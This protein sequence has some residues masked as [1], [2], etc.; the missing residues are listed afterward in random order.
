MGVGEQVLHQDGMFRITESVIPWVG[1]ASTKKLDGRF[2][3][4]QHD[5]VAVRAILTALKQLSK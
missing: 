1:T 3:V 4:Q 5:S 2:V